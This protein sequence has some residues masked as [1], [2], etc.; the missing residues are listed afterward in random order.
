MGQSTVLM[1]T[2]SKSK[3]AHRSFSEVESTPTA[4]KAMV[5]RP[6]RGDPQA[7]IVGLPA[8]L[9]PCSGQAAVKESKVRFNYFNVD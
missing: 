4:A 2:L 1:R 3:L 7:V 5:G 6:G 9:R 8:A